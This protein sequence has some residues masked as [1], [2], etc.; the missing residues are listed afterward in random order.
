[1]DREHAAVHL[2]TEWLQRCHRMV[3]VRRRAMSG[4]LFAANSAHYG[5]PCHPN[6][7]SCLSA[8]RRQAYGP[9]GMCGAA[10][11]GPWYIAMRGLHICHTAS[12]GHM[13]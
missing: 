3:V 7:Q 9:E 4:R 11:P 13:G 8:D 10:L 5:M 12:Y 1:M 2:N 6:G